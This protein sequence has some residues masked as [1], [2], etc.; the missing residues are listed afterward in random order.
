[1][2]RSV[3][4]L[5]TP[6][7]A[8]G[9]MFRALTAIA[10][11]RYEAVTWVNAFYAAGRL[12]D[13]ASAVPPVEDHLIKHNAPERFNPRTRLS[14]YRF[15]LNARD[16]RD[17]VCN[18]YHWQFVHPAPHETEAE[19]EARRRRVA[20][21]GIDAFALQQD[22]T[23]YLRGFLDVARRI[24]PP[25]RIF[26]GYAMYC[27]HFD[28]A[29]TRASEFMGIAPGDWTRPQRKALGR[30]RVENLEAN[31]SWVGQRWAGS[32]KAPGRYRQELQPATIRHLNQRYGWFLDFLRRMDDPR[33]VPT[34]G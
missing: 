25:D 21:E 4:F 5:S 20:A 14:D 2:A 30:E 6:T 15:I 26:V 1:M 13:I 28:A 29:M 22:N 16:P 8:N 18:Q 31:P 33:V 11:G 27:L 17:M 9:S 19:T 23:P 10:K 34:Y 32:D 3:I 12:E 7:S 24:A